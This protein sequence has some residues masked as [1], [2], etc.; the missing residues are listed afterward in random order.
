MASDSSSSSSNLVVPANNAVTPESKGDPNAGM[1]VLCSLV[2]LAAVAVGYHSL[3]RTYGR[4]WRYHA[5]YWGAAVVLTLTVGATPAAPY[6]WSDLTTTV[7]GVALPIYESVRAVCTPGGSDDKAWLQYWE[8]GGVLFLSTTWVDHVLDDN[9]YWD[10]FLTFGF[11]W[12]Y[13]PLTDGAVLIYDKVTLPFVVPHVR[14]LAAKMDNLIAML[15]QTMINAVH[16]WILWIVFL[17]LPQG[18]KRILA[19]CIGT[20]YPLVSSIAAS[21]TEDYEDDTYWLTYWSCYGCLFLVMD[22]LYVSI[23]VTQKK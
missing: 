20:V 17:F 2:L 8:F 5:M 21:A 22:I 10:A 14:P 15:Y 3:A 23:S 7:L 13:F 18:L 1:V 4:V 19:V 9:L 12:L 11:V 6:M 16:L